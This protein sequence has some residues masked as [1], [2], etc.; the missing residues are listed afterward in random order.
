[1]K[2]LTFQAHFNGK[3]ILP[4]YPVELVVNTKLLVTVLEP[5]QASDS[6]PVNSCLLVSTPF[7]PTARRTTSASNYD[8]W[9]PVSAASWRA[10]GNQARRCLLGRFRQPHWLCAWLSASVSRHPKQC[11]QS[12]SH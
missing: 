10:N 9:L 4:D 11:F 12:E 6:L 3:Q 7:M 2:N 1:M 8:K 5:T